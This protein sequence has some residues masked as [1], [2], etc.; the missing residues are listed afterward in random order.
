M[1]MDVMTALCKTYVNLSK[2]E[3]DYKNSN[4]KDILL[5]I[6]HGYQTVEI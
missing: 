5:P 2:Q 3:I 6:S 4:Q 1:H